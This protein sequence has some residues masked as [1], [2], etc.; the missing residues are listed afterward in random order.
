MVSP[1]SKLR[2][3]KGILDE[4]ELSHLLVACIIC[5]FIT[6]GVKATQSPAKSNAVKTLIVLTGAVVLFGLIVATGS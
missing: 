5:F 2:K 3:V 1:T 4:V 6:F